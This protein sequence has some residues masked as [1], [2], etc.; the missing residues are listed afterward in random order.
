MRANSSQSQDSINGIAIDS[1]G[2][3]VGAGSIASGI[4][5]R[6]AVV[7]YTAAGALDTSFGAGG[8]TTTSFTTHDVGAGIV[9]QPDGKLVVGSH[10]G[11]SFTA[12]R[13][14]NNGSLDTTFGSGGHT[15]VTTGTDVCSGVALQSNGDIVLGGY[16]NRSGNFVCIVDRFTSSGALDTSFNATGT[17]TAGSGERMGGLALRSDGTVDIT[18]YN[19]T[20]QDFNTFQFTSSG[21]LDT[22][23]GGG[24]VVTE[25]TIPNKASAAFTQVQPDGKILIAGPYTAGNANTGSGQFYVARLDANGTLDN[26]FGNNGILTHAIGRLASMRT[27]LL[28]PNGDI[29]VG[30]NTGPVGSTAVHAYAIRFLPSGALDTT[31]GVNGEQD[32]TLLSGNTSLIAL[33]PKQ[34]G[35]FSTVISVST[36]TDILQLTSAGQ[37][38]LNFGTSGLVTSTQSYSVA[39]IDPSDD[40]V[41]IV[42]GGTH[43]DRFL[44]SG[45]IDTTFNNTS[46][47]Y[48]V[49]AEGGV[50]SLLCQPDR[51][52][53]VVGGVFSSLGTDIE[54]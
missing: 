7:R 26:T 14:L 28:Q 1:S 48:D 29:I 13:Y 21:A 38:D 34:D 54:R 17:I 18:G 22:T 35:S 23:F 53:L 25:F 46:T 27:M 15:T 2:R 12:L 40:I 9:I 31:F 11:N 6:C 49:E 52:I 50:N 47:N 45:A 16:G 33:L 24:E 19:A 44:P 51:K 39:A 37:V 5:Y 4:T 43:L 8:F 30:G 32:F 36:G 41:A 3:I 20:N 42:N 10:S